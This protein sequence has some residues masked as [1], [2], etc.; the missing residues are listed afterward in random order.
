VGQGQEQGEV[1]AVRILLVVMLV[2]ACVPALAAAD[3][4][5][6]GVPAAAREGAASSIVIQLDPDTFW[7]PEGSEV[8]FT[9]ASNSGGLPQVAQVIVCFR[10]QGVDAA[11]N[12]LGYLPSPL[13][14]SIANDSGQVGYGALIPDL[15][16]LR[17]FGI[18]PGGLHVQH[19]ALG[20]VPLADMAVM[21]QMAGGGPP[22]AVILPV[23]VTN[24]GVAGAIVLVCLAIAILVL[25][26]L[27]P[28]DM[29]SGE[30]GRWRAISEHFLAVI[31]N[32]EGVASLSQF[33]VLLWTLVVAAAA[34]YVM[35]LSGNLITIS[36]QMLTLLGIAGGTQ[37]LASLDRKTLPAGTPYPPPGRPQ[38]SQML[39][40][41]YS[42][43]I[44]VTRVQMLIFT[45]ITAAFVAVQVIATYSIPDISDNFM[46]LM[47]I[48]NGVY[49]AGRQTAAPGKA[50]PG[51]GP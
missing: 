37:I 35:V 42:H 44:D 4:S 17:F 12:P 28:A 48:S 14:R 7:R 50:P 8:R 31:S 10:W 16:S 32:P 41:R 30:P 33:Q 27:A 11:G 46:V 13:V 43:E 1:A 21:V 9:V 38:W 25:W 18:G 47:G 51:N 49:L 5:C 6:G 45:L 39:V 29:L 40:D 26:K 34:I 22:V 20:T 36:S 3:P 19:T 24:A 2:L 23:G 15:G